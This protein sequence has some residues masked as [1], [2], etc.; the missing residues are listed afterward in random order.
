[1]KYF[2]YCRKSSEDKQRQVLSIQSQQ[3]EA[4]RA[5][6][7]N[8]DI[9]IVG[10]FE[11][12]RS[13]M[14]PGRPIF[15]DM[16]GRIERGV[17]EGIIAWSPDRLA[18]NSI[19]GG[20]I[21]YLLDRGIIR[22]LK[23]STY[24]FE[25]NSQG[26]FMLQIMFGQSKYYSDALSENVRRGIRT[27]I[28]NGWW[29]T[30]APLGYVNDKNTSTIAIDPERFPLI[31]NML[32]MMLSGAYSVEQIWQMSLAWGLRTP[33]RRKLGGK[34]LALSTVYKILYNPFYAGVIAWNGKWHPGKHQPMI[35]LDEHHRIKAMLSRPGRT[36]PKRLSFV[37]TGLLTCGSCGLSVTAERKTNRFGSHYT[38]YHCTK[39]LRPRCDEPS[40]EVEQF[41]AQ[42]REFLRGLSA[43]ERF[44]RWSRDAVHQEHEE[45]RTIVSSEA[46][47]IARAIDDTE[48]RI[49]ELGEMRSRRL[50]Q[51]AEYLAL[52]EG[53]ERELLQL[54]QSAKDR[55]TKEVQWFEPAEAVLSFSN[56][57]IFWFDE[58][59]DEEKRLIF[60]AVGSNPT[61]SRKIVSIHARKPFQHLPSQQSFPNWRA[62]ANHIRK[63]VGA[64]D[65][66]TAMA[67]IKRLMELRAARLGAM[68]QA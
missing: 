25:N 24:T 42:V 29:P 56:H 10:A 38:Y 34:P 55:A 17:A 62:F 60:I 43:P 11:E 52:R 4:A 19:D 8:P 23:F 65:L 66:E 41:E 63:M 12:E 49:L 22:D 30:I 1:M 48:R 53:A 2:I 44:H 31:Q 16:I 61:L 54:R 26:K 14:K 32:R 45:G 28:E 68:T 51:D 33:M 47:A 27:K 39:R 21:I 35:A 59:T 36:K 9:E 64:S 67:A 40:I 13:A 6:S 7:G 5:F 15:A 57:A 46:R 50:V 37:Y 18:R 3:R 58:G 20:Q